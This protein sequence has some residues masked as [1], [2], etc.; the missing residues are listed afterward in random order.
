MTD[1]ASPPAPP[2]PAPA[3]GRGSSWLEQARAFVARIEA[4]AATDPGARAALRSGLG[5]PLDEARRMHRIV[6]PWIPASA[7]A[8][9]DTQRA[10]Y[11]VASLIAAQKTAALRAARPSAPGEP[12]PAGM[13]PS[14]SGPGGDTS[15]APGEAE[16]AAT[17]AGPAGASLYGRS[18]GLTF[19]AAVAAG[20]RE[21][22]R[23]STAE[24]RL[25][26]LTRQS[27]AGLHRHLPAT[28]RQL[29]DKNTP[30]DW[31]QLLVDLRAWPAD[32]KR[33][34]R[35]WLQDYY[36]ARHQ[37]ELE[38]ARAAAEGDQPADALAL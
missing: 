1:T 26:L 24:T 20:A 15:V 18:L 10:F 2:S 37:A 6:A 22:L 16:P 14:A 30:P 5:K 25:N 31:A 23:E 9:D 36:R 3:A 11:T 28:V 17:S 19:A 27:T 4:I 34:G 38:A 8:G 35:R 29:C 21:G 32:R 7:M 13:S 33:I 12:A